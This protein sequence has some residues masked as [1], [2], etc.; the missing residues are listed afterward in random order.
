MVT[1][2]W[3]LLHKE[4]N[5]EV[6]KVRALTLAAPSCQLLRAMSD[7]NGTQ[8]ARH[9]VHFGTLGCDSHTYSA[10]PGAGLSHR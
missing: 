10:V 1:F 4:L 9:L 8:E 7:A 6:L 3:C 2:F 5:A